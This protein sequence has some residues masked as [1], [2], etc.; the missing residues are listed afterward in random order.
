MPRIIPT[1]D[2]QIGK[3]FG[4]LGAD[5][6]RLA[7]LRQA[8]IDVVRRIGKVA[9]ERGANG[10]LVAGDVFERNE[11]SDLVVRQT[12]TAMQETTV[13]WVLLPGNHDPDGPAGVWDRIE[14]IGHGPQV[15]VARC[16]EP[17][18]LAD[19]RLAILPA[20]LARK[21]QFADPTE[22]FCALKTPADAARIGL[23]HG[24]L[25]NRLAPGAETHNMI[26][27]DR[28]QTA[29]LDYL[30]LGD[31]HSAQEVAPRTWYAG[32]PEPDNFD[33]D[34]GSVLIVDIPGP[35]ETPVVERVSVSRY[36]WH[37][38]SVN[39]QSPDA[40]QQLKA[41]VAQLCE[42]L[43]R[44]V[45]DISLTGAISLADRNAV[46]QELARVQAACQV[47]R[48]HYDQLLEEPT[49]ADLD[50]LGRHGFIATVV[51]RLRM[52]EA[53]HGGADSTYAR[54]ALRRL[55]VEHVIGGH[56]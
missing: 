34:S 2:L 25:R 23:A 16:Q 40:A 38:L 32:T 44:A 9:E 19:D 22:Q 35:G 30:A 27:D 54:G 45:I 33:Q 49:E 12:L 26:A 24:S 11:V 3:Q 51:S 8:R 36:H 6:D 41:A 4:N 15:S 28:A 18:L 17:V 55:Y 50:D 13:P 53:N 37:K 10:I 46:E 42:P 7:Y 48:G 14:R 20:P 31:W 21:H 52:L 39:L 5:V 29:G 47:L 43:S 1:A 56:Q